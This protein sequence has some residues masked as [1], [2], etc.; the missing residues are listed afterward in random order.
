VNTSLRPGRALVFLALL[1]IIGLLATAGPA[2]AVDDGSLGIRPATESD[3]FHLELSP[4]AAIDATAIV[5]NHSAD[6]VTLADYPVD[7]HTTPQG[8]FGM[9]A[10]TDTRSEVGAWMHLANDGQVTVPAGSELSVAF[11]LVVPKD[12]PPGDYVG[13]LIIQATAVIGKTSTLKGGAAVRLDVVQRQ[14]VRVYLHVAGTAIKQLAAG[15]MSWTSNADSATFSLPM[16]NSGN[17][18]L[19]PTA[20]LRVHGWFGLDREVKLTADDAV[21]PGATY[22]FTTTVR[23]VPVIT[24]GAADTTIRSEAPAE[25]VHSYFSYVPWLPIIGILVVLLLLG[26]G[27]WRTS[28][29]VRKAL[30]ALAPR[31]RGRV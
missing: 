28:R 16:T 5:S 29:W 9:G 11:R 6:P 17:T 4:G 25:T 21:L 14:G 27:V 18:I 20:T 30:R 13:A 7:A 24:F 31:H 22:T 19:H 10:Q 23:S 1:S 15:L 3:F 8:G 12:T 2:S 26:F